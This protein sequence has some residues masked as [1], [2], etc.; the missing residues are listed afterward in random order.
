MT[1]CGK[2]R[3]GQTPR[4]GTDWSEPIDVAEEP[5]RLDREVFQKLGIDCPRTDCDGH[6]VRADALCVKRD[7]RVKARC[8]DQDIIR[9]IVCA[10]ASDAEV[11][12]EGSRA[13]SPSRPDY[14]RVLGG[15]IG[16]LDSGADD[17]LDRGAQQSF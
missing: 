1:K 16:L 11:D 3:A 15:N 2:Q 14:R 8:A 5:G 12:R 4:G 6:G 10:G 7:L 9:Q 17:G 13:D